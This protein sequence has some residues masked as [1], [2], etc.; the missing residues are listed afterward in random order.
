MA[1][2]EV[3]ILEDLAFVVVITS[4][5][6]VVIKAADRFH[7]QTTRPNEMWQGS[8]GSKRL[9]FCL[10]CWAT[11]DVRRSHWQSELAWL[12]RLM[13]FCARPGTV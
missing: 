3:V 9:T 2:F 6:C 5:A 1:R 11:I 10:P 13:L 7:T 12:R 4:P 8:P